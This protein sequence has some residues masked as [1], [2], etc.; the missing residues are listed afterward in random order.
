MKSH[1]QWPQIAKAPVTVH[2]GASVSIAM[3]KDTR[4]VPLSVQRRTTLHKDRVI[5][6][7]GPDVEKRSR[8]RLAAAQP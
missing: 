1:R 5:G 6:G 2:I 7:G 3:L 8:N 4:H